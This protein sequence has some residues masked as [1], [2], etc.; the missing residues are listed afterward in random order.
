MR[1]Q[2]S[3]SKL[4]ILLMAFVLVSPVMGSSVSADSENLE[5]IISISEPTDESTWYDD[6][7]PLSMAITIK[8][9]GTS[10]ES[11]EYNPSCPVAIAMIADGSTF[12]T[13]NDHRTC[14]Q[15]R[16]AIDI[17]AGQTR[18]LDT[19]DWNWQNSTT[20]II[21]SG[22]ISLNFDF[23]NGLASHIENLQF[24][25]SPV[26]IDG[27]MLNINSAPVL[28]GDSNYLMGESVYSYISLQNNGNEV[29]T[30]NADEGCR[31]TL[32]ISSLETTYPETMT[33]LGCGSG[34]SLGVGDTLSLGW[35]E[36]DFTV[37]GAPVTPGTWTLDVSSTGLTGLSST[38]EVALD[39]IE[40]TPT[41]PLDVSISLIGDGGS[42]DVVTDADNLQIVT[43]LINNDAVPAEIQFND[44]CLITIAI[45]SEQGNLVGDSRLTDS[46]QT[47]YSELKIGATDQLDIDHRLWS[48]N[49]LDGC[50]L[51]DGNYLIIATIGEFNTASE[52]PF[53][54][55]GSDSGPTCRA[56]LQ[57]TSLTQFSVVDMVTNN[58]GA[59]EES[60][61]FKLQLDNQIDLD[62]HWPQACHLSFTLTKAGNSQPERVWGEDCENSGGELG[63]IPAGHGI[64][65]GP[66]TIEFGELDE[67]T[68]SLFVET[69]GTP[70]F[71]TQLAHTWN[72]LTE[73]VEEDAQVEDGSEETPDQ[74]TLP[75]EEVTLQS[76]LSEGSWK[77][78]TTE[79]GG[80]WLLVDT[81]GV[82]HAYTS[83]QIVDWQPLPNHRGAYWVEESLQSSAA[84]AT[85]ASHIVVVE[86]LGEAIDTPEI[87]SDDDNMASETPIISIPAA[88]PTIVAI[89]A[90]TSLL[91][92]LAGAFT[93]IEWIRLPA[94]KYGL[95]LIGMVRR[96]KESGGEYQRGRIVAYIELHRGIHFRALLGALDM[97]NGQ[98]AHH[99][100]VLESDDRVWRRKD[101]RKVRYYPASIDSSTSNDDLPVPLLTPDPNSLQGKILQILDIH[102]NE[103]LNLS[104]KELSDK[105]ATSQ[106][107]VSYHLK[108][109]EDWGLVEKERVAMRYRYR[110]TDRALILL[111][112]SEFP[113][114][115]DDV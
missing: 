75:E 100:S 108:S 65:F 40:P 62:V 111:N 95:A 15:Q 26:L 96:T 72:S 37:E 106:Q 94:T 22:E 64:L 45:I 69:T 38:I 85:W 23:E 81:N 78:V 30:I 2:E 63:T 77:Y 74:T 113:S 42:D 41:F 79:V 8:N 24:Q 7:T 107:L 98:L 61:T 49:D 104:Q 68:W 48:M 11:I 60:I 82:E 59:A 80:C 109:L 50:E 103:I 47:E 70:Y 97:S 33:E 25:R 5:L 58:E 93:Q 16:R 35:L 27:L 92:L 20:S 53:I 51:D 84:C 44:S 6:L 18:N 56:S 88:A 99:L 3:F 89:V 83:S 4:L 71:T 14:Q 105:L 112:T 115:G 110:L 86:V 46:C 34:S 31:L 76:W 28:S 10:T 36:W 9:T 12:S 21:P 57:D 52:Y 73:Q 1:G 67:G 43:S 13:L 17:P 19:F 54:Y 29:I 87:V 91:A 66:Y 102:E 90:S 32:Q 114:F 39:L 55:D 101:G